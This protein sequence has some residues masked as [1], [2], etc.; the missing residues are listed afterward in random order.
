LKTLRNIIRREGGFTLTELAVAMLVVGILSGIAVPSFL[1]ARNNAYDKEAQA[2]IDSALIAAQ[3]H[4]AQYGDFSDSVSDTCSA[5]SILAGDLQK[6]DP[7]LN[8]VVAADVSTGPRVVSVQANTTWNAN[9]ESMGCQAFYATALSRSG[10]CWVARLTVEGK[11]LV[12]PAGSP[13]VATSPIVLKSDENTAASSITEYELLPVNGKAYA[14]FKPTNSSADA[15]SADTD[16]LAN[17]K[18]ACSGAMQGTGVLLTATN[19]VASTEF[20]SSWRSVVGAAAG[21]NI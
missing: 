10:T 15:S 1:G 5:T 20:Y 14:A 18:T 21:S 11:F 17:A 2:A 13:L 16:T 12:T 8:M 7:T 3:T 9:S 6:Q 19:K 4:Y